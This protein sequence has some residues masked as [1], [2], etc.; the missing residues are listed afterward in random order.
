MGALINA[1][2]KILNIFYSR[3][4]NIYKNMKFFFLIRV[5]LKKNVVILK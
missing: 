4:F 3:L 1:I 2:F 5:K